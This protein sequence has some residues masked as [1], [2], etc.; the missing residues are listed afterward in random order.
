MNLLRG[1]R[2]REW[3]DFEWTENTFG[4]LSIPT[5]VIGIILFSFPG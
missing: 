2:D 1:M 4:Y 5:F 3:I